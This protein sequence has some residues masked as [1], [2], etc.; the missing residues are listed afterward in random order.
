MYPWYIM[1][2]LNSVQVYP[3]FDSWFENK[4]NYKKKH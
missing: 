2:P 3:D 1:E 4:A